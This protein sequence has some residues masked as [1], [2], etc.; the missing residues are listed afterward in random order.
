MQHGILHVDKGILFTIKHLLTRPGAFIREYIDGNRAGH[1]K[2]V[3]LVMILGAVAALTGR[4]VA[5]GESSVSE[6]WTGLYDGATDSGRRPDMSASDARILEVMKSALE[7]VSGHVP[8]VLIMLVPVFALAMRAAFHS[9]R[10]RATYPEWLVISCFMVAQALLAYIIVAVIGR[11]IPVL[12]NFDFLMMIG[13]QSWA[14]VRIFSHR[15]WYAVLSRFFAG[16]MFYMLMFT[17]LVVVLSVAGLVA[18]NGWDAF[19]EQVR[20]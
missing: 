5:A 3:L 14:A 11:F 18:A 9:Y 7:W 2:P 1:F 12:G 8:L 10:A 19:M 17:T 16:Y 15:R 13:L 6:A 4:V 20:Q